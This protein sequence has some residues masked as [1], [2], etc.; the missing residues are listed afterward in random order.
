MPHT[1]AIDDLIL[2][3]TDG[4]L[5]AHQS[6]GEHGRY[7]LVDIDDATPDLGEFEGKG[8]AETPEHSVGGIGPIAID[9]RLG[10]AG[11]EEQLR[12]L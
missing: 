8:A 10:V 7:R 11:Q 4:G 1:R 6:G 5:I 12:R 9:D 2:T 3:V